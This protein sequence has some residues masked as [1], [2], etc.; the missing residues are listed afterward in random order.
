MNPMDSVGIRHHFGGGV[1]AKE[2]LIP[3]GLKLTQH[4]HS[5]DHLSVLASGSVLV[6]DGVVS[7]RY[8]APACV[9]IKA[10]IPHEVVSIT[11]AVWYCI[12]ATEE[13]DPA[14]VDERLIA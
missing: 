5:F 2:T 7:Q 14:K 12:H 4:E 13:T 11:D 10:G 1:Y 3:A 6:G 8:D 9:L